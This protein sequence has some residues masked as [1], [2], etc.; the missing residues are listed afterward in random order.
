MLA[1]SEYLMIRDDAREKQIR[2]EK[3]FFFS[4]TAM[5]ITLFALWN[6]FE[7]SASSHRERADEKR[8]F[9]IHK[10]SYDEVRREFPNR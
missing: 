2:P 8:F 7:V 10:R 4:G 5:R 9:F 3:L 1:I 6:R